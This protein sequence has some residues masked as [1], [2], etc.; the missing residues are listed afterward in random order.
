MNAPPG[1]HAQPRLALAAVLLLSC[2]RAV[3]AAP[4]SYLERLPEQEI[5]YFLLPDR[6]AK[7]DPEPETARTGDRLVTGYDPTDPRFYHGGSL[8]G[9]V[10]QLGYIQAL[11]ATA[12]WIAPVFVNQPVQGPAGHES[13]AYHGYW[14]TDFLHVDPHLGTDADLHA[15][16]NAAHARGMKVYLDIV[17]NHTADVIRY[18]ECPVAPCPYRSEAQYP[19]T[20]RGGLDGAAINDGFLGLDAPYQTDANFAHLTR[21]DYAYTPYLPP[22]QEHRKVPDWLNDPI[23]Y[24]NRGDTTWSG[25]SLQLGD[26]FGLDDLMTEHPRVLRGMIEIFGYWI[27]QYRLDGFR[28]DTEQHVNA[29]FWRAF[30]PAMLARAAAVGIS[31]FHMFGEVATN[32][33]DTAL[34]ARHV[35]EDG[36]PA[37]LDFAFAAAVRDTVAGEAGT[38]KLARVFADDELF[39]GGAA[40]ARQLPTFI[41]NHDAGRFGYLVRRARPRIEVGEQLRRVLLANA[42]LLT[43][44][45]VPVLYYGDEQGF[46]GDGGDASARQDMFAT[47]VAKYTHEARLGTATTGS[48][49]HYQMTH[50]LYVALSELAHLRLAH[51]ALLLGRQQTRAAGDTPGLFAVSRFDPADG[52][53]IVLAFN[54]SLQAIDA[55]VRVDARSGR[56]RALHGE[57]DAESSAPGSYRVRVP[58][59]G[60]VIC[61]AEAGA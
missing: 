59:L 20:R 30:V 44:R 56:F 4:P 31:H 25:E 54:T 52:H 11:G 12:L 50:P 13:A 2:A 60:Y 3:G 24:H 43:L 7:S 42:L 8:R 18:R 6:F 36:I 32:T 19:Y 48:G 55:V 21:P 5:I 45:G 29:E 40:T 10:R 39:A 61:E 22:G 9:V 34:L 58:E 49:D 47:R 33:T 57:C 38:A 1:T 16:V 26:F 28:I 46:L 14:I 17:V 27:E 53:E 37:V 23:Y 51:P 15:L 41:S 35:R